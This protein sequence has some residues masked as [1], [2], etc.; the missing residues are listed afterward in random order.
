MDV[1]DTYV[2]APGV[3]MRRHADWRKGSSEV[4]AAIGPLLSCTSDWSLT[5]AILV[6]GPDNVTPY[7]GMGK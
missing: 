7:S 4:I 5:A 1:Q 2:A 6:T 3:L